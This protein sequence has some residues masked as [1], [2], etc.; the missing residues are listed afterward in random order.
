MSTARLD[1]AREEGRAME[2]R[3]IRKAL[4]ELRAV[5]V[6]RWDDHAEPVARRW[7]TPEGCARAIQA[8]EEA[9]KACAPTRGR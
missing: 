7:S 9:I 1:A 8:L 6:S 2:R 3:R 5:Y 4:R